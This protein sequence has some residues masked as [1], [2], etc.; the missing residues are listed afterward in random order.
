MNKEQ[1]RTVCL[2]E[3]EHQIS[4][5]ESYEN[6][7]RFDALYNMNS[8]R[9]YEFFNGM[10][11]SGILGTSDA[12]SQ[13]R[14]NIED[15]GM[16]IGCFFEFEFPDIMDNISK[17]HMFKIIEFDISYGFKHLE[18]RLLKII[19]GYGEIYKNAKIVS[20]Q[21]RVFD[22]EFFDFMMELETE[23]Q[24]EID[25][26]TKTEE[27]ADSNFDVVKMWKQKECA[28][29]QKILNFVRQKLVEPF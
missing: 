28:C 29:E 12:L 18:P 4:R 21:V 27:F 2:S 5:A 17:S 6:N 9:K 15:D 7:P 19:N 22:W 24:T 23:Y 11:A 25:P 13:I 20:I 10:F 1:I 26:I 8:Q 14:Y 16:M 3:L